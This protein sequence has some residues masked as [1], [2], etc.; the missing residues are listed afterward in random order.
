M[1]ISIFPHFESHSFIHTLS[2]SPSLSPS[3][4][5]SSVCPLHT[6]GHT[7]QVHT[8]TLAAVHT[9]AGKPAIAP[10]LFKVNTPTVVLLGLK[11]ANLNEAHSVLGTAQ[12]RDF[13]TAT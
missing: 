6:P 9:L 5:L 1:S 2:L 10:C 7:P 3:F 13:P 11:Q 12:A 4:T 8:D